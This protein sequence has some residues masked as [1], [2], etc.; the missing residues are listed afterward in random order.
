MS[1]FLAAGWVACAGSLMLFILI[2]RQ[3]SDNPPSRGLAF[4]FSSKCFSFGQGGLLGKANLIS[5]LVKV[6]FARRGG[7]FLSS[8]MTGRALHSC[9]IRH[10][11]RYVLAPVL[12]ASAFPWC[13]SAGRVCH[14][15]ETS[16]GGL[17]SLLIFL[18]GYYP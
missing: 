18:V 13:F 14:G 9:Q 5:R 16:Y 10:G 15:E 7:N 2:W 17:H 1:V 6:K 12:E 8:T 3:T 11:S 4:F